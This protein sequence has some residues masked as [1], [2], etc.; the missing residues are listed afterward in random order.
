MC[1]KRSIFSSYYVELLKT[2]LFYVY[3]LE[4]LL[5]YEYLDKGNTPFQVFPLARMRDPGRLKVLRQPCNRVKID[6]EIAVQT[7]PDAPVVGIDVGIANFITT[8]TGKQYGTM[9]GKLK[10]RHKQGRARCRK[11]AKLRACLKKKDVTTKLPS[12]SSWTGQRLM[13]QTNT[14]NQSLFFKIVLRYMRRPDA[15]R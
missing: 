10:A 1:M 6:S 5:I 12:T 3:E 2:H 11:K 15:D 7:A 9:H 4:L 14:G 8:S 13:R